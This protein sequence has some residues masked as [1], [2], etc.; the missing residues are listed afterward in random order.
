MK[1]DLSIIK[2]NNYWYE[3][4]QIHGIRHLKYDKERYQKPV[5]KDVL[6]NDFKKTDY[7]EKRSKAKVKSWLIKDLKVK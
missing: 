2:T 5:G 3:N 7:L 4:N 1:G 6:F